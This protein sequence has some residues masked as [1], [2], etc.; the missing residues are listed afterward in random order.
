MTEVVGRDMDA[1]CPCLLLPHPPCS[2]NVTGRAV[3]GPAPAADVLDTG[4][5][6]VQVVWWGG[7]TPYLLEGVKKQADNYALY[8]VQLYNSQVVPVRKEWN[9]IQNT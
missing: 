6:R 7:A 9:I 4:P 8:W 3:T 5:L 1:V 2:S